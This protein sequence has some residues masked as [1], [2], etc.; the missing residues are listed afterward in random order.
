MAGARAEA[1]RAATFYQKLG[2]PDR[3][4]FSAHPG[5]HEFDTQTILTFFD[6]HL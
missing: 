2:V 3:F 6:R 5:G 1:A 4:Q